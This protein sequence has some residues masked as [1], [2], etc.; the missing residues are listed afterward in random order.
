[1]KVMLFASTESY[2]YNFRRWLALYDA[3][4]EVAL[5]SPRCKAGAP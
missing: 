5:V 2:L 1:M 4:H 3:G